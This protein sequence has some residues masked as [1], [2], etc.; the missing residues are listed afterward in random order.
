MAVQS[1]PIQTISIKLGYIR[2]KR[3]FDVVFTLLLA[4]P[5]LLIS[6]AIAVLIVLDSRGPIIFRQK[7][8]GRDGEE[9]E[10]LKF[11]SMYVNNDDTRHR[12]AIEHYMNGEMLNNGTDS[13]YK[14]LDDSRVT[15]IGKFIRATSLDELPQFW[16]VLRG[17][18]SL[19]GPRPPVP[20]EVEMYSLHDKLRLAGSP[21]LTG[22]WQVHGRSRVPFEEMIE[23]DIAYLQQQSLWEDFKII[24]LTIPVVIQKRGGA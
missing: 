13:P 10:M 23:M 14:S 17:D 11:R 9:F 12:E 7:R 2:S 18:M 3:V 4:I 1:A 8:I 21:G 16:N 15:R 20:Y 5:V 19:V 22:S 6:A 24:L